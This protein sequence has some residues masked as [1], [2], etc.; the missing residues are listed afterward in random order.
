MSQM[1][2]RRYGL[3]F[4]GIGVLRFRVKPLRGARCLSDS[5]YHA[6]V[7]RI[8]VREDVKSGRV[9]FAMVIASPWSIPLRR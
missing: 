9:A 8:S 7:S 6:F 2:L 5:R 3:A 1:Y 4:A